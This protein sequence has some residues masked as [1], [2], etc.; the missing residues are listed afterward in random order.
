MTGGY[1]YMSEAGVDHIGIVPGHSGGF[2]FH[3]FIYPILFFF[4]K[5]IDPVG[6]PACIV[7]IVPCQI[8]TVA[9]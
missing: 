3:G 4:V 1:A 2:A 5:L 6:D 8:L 9:S 7:I